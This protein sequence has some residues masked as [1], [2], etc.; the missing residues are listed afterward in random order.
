MNQP[1]NPLFSYFQ[2]TVFKVNLNFAFYA[3]GFWT[4]SNISHYHTIINTGEATKR[5]MRV[6][7][8]LCEISIAQF[9]SLVNSHIPRLSKLLSEPETVQ[10]TTNRTTFHSRE[11][12]SFSKPKEL[13]IRSYYINRVFWV[14]AFTDLSAAWNRIMPKRGHE[15][16][17]P[18]IK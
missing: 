11:Q 12:I 8:P 15:F 17:I 18:E 14:T 4:L 5:E 16:W 10:T 13:G 9:L 2:N 3:S 1:P 6:W 7:C